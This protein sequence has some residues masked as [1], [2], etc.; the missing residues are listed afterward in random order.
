MISTSSSD[1]V[2]DFELDNLNAF[3]ESVVDDFEY[4]L[5]DPD[6]VRRTYSPTI[7]DDNT[8]DIRNDS[9]SESDDSD[10]S[11][12]E[13]VNDIQSLKMQNTIEALQL[14]CVNFHKA[15]SLTKFDPAKWAVFRLHFP[16]LRPHFKLSLHS[17]DPAEL[18]L[19]DTGCFLNVI[20]KDRRQELISRFGWEL[21]LEPTRITLRSHTGHVVPSLGIISLSVFIPDEKGETVTFPDVKFLVTRDGGHLLLGNGFLLGRQAHLQYAMPAEAGMD[22]VDAKIMFPRRAIS[23]PA[24]L[25]PLKPPPTEGYQFRLYPVSEHQ[26]LP[27][28]KDIPIQC[29]VV[30]TDPDHDT[31]IRNGLGIAELTAFTN[32]LNSEC[33]IS[34]NNDLK[35]VILLRNDSEYPTAVNKEMC[36]GMGEMVGFRDELCAD[37]T[38][39]SHLIHTVAQVEVLR[40]HKCLCQITAQTIVACFVD[41]FGLSQIPYHNAFESADSTIPSYVFVPPKGKKRGQNPHL[42]IRAGKVTDEVAKEIVA[43]CPFRSKIIFVPSKEGFSLL[44]TATI[45][46]IQ[47]Q[48]LQ[49][50]VELYVSY[51]E[52][53]RRHKFYYYQPKSHTIVH[54][55]FS[56]TKGE[57]LIAPFTKHHKMR[58]C[59]PQGGTGVTLF[60]SSQRNYNYFVCKIDSKFK[61]NQDKCR[62]RVKETLHLLRLHDPQTQMCVTTN[63]PDEF[64]PLQRALM[65]EMSAYPGEVGNLKKLFVTNNLMCTREMIEIK[66]EVKPIDILDAFEEK[67]DYEMGIASIVSLIDREFVLP[68]VYQKKELQKAI[69]MGEAHEDNESHQKLL[70][71]IEQ[72]PD[73]ILDPVQ[74]DT[75]S[76]QSFDTLFDREGALWDLN[77]EHGDDNKVKTWRDLEGVFDDLDSKDKKDFYSGLYDKYSSIINLSKTF[78]NISNCPKFDLNPKVTQLSQKP[79]PLS[80]FHKKIMFLLIDKMVACGMLKEV[81]S[82][83]F[84]SPVFLVRRTSAMRHMGEKEF[85]ELSEKDPEKHW[86]AVVSFVGLNDTVPI[87]QSFLPSIP[88]LIDKFQGSCFFSS[89]DISSFYRQLGLTDRA[90]EAMTIVVGTDPPT[91]YQPQ[92][93]LE[94][95]ASVVQFANW[96]TGQF[97]RKRS[98]GSCEYYLDD[99]FLYSNSIEGIRQAAEDVLADL[100][101]ANLFFSPLKC[102]WEVNEINCLGYTIRYCPEDG[103]VRW[104]PQSQK[105][106][107][108]QEAEYPKN[109]HELMR[110]LGSVAFCSNFVDNL[111]NLS[112]SLYSLLARYNKFGKFTE[113]EMTETEKLSFRLLMKKMSNME[114]LAVCGAGYPLRGLVDSGHRGYAGTLFIIK[115]GKP[116]ICA[117]Y[118]KRYPASFVRSRS[119]CEKESMA[120]MQFA[121][122]FQDRVF[123]A[124]SVTFYSDCRVFLCLLARGKGVTSG[125]IPLRW[126]H[127]LSVLPIRFQHRPRHLLALPDYLARV[128][129]KEKKHEHLTWYAAKKDL[130]RCQVNPNKLK[131]DKAYNINDLEDIVVNSGN[132]LI[133]EHPEDCDECKGLDDE[134]E[135]CSDFECQLAR[136]LEQ[137]ESDEED[138]LEEEAIEAKAS[139]LP[140]PIQNLPVVKELPGA[141][142]DINFPTFPQTGFDVDKMVK[143][144]RSDPEL[145]KIIQTL[146][147][148]RPVPRRMHQYHLLDGTMLCKKIDLKKEATKD[149]LQIMVPQSAFIK[150]VVDS[151]RMGHMSPSKLHDLLKRF[152]YC[153]H[154][155]NLIKLVSASCRTCVLAKVNT[156]GNL[157]QGML[158]P[159][160]RTYGTLSMDYWYPGTPTTRNG[161]QYTTVLTIVDYFSL[162]VWC[163]PMKNTQTD[164]FLKQ[165]DFFLGTIPA[166]AVDFV[167][168]DNAQGLGATQAVKDYFAKRNI[169]VRTCTPYN[170]QAQLA[171]RANQMIRN[172][173]RVTMHSYDKDW[174][175][176]LPLAQRL[177]NAIPHH[178][179][180]KKAQGRSP[181]EIAFGIVSPF[182]PLKH[183]VTDQTSS[184]A[185][186]RIRNVISQLQRA[187][188]RVSQEIIQ[189]R[190]ATSKIKKGVTVALLKNK[191]DRPYKQD[192]YYHQRP[193]RV[194]HKKGHELVIV[195][196]NN[197]TRKLRVNINRVKLWGRLPKSIFDQLSDDQKEDFV[198]AA[199]RKST[200]TPEPEPPL[201]DRAKTP[202]TTERA[203]VFQ[204]LA[205]KDDEKSSSD[206]SSETS[207]QQEQTAPSE[208]SSPVTTT[209]TKKSK[210]SSLFRSVISRIRKIAPSFSSLRSRSKTNSTVASST[211]IQPPDSASQV[212][213]NL[214]PPIVTAGNQSNNQQDASKDQSDKVSQRSSNSSH[215][216]TRDRP[217]RKTAGQKAKDP[218][219]Q[220]F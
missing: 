102:K 139:D 103:V 191:A 59:D 20:S 1:D 125:V 79:F 19:V 9:D 198:P 117:F 10:D 33:V 211:T 37:V 25:G 201:P 71:E 156:S 87:P 4:H 218:A 206:S 95:I 74:H 190:L 159:A 24:P 169:Q 111:A 127:V 212:P 18:V 168:T 186:R 175:E 34:I 164:Q 143:E 147:M 22:N 137:F 99:C 49:T 134:P 129:S 195:P 38:P 83:R 105:I 106:K 108:F 66:R 149:N 183:L 214:T 110:I 58:A 31:K 16:T 26:E 172:V 50:D 101:E 29:N 142:L 203:D 17:K 179:R 207:V 12:V 124:E 217:Q 97:I 109:V 93:V 185:R 13:M 177:L 94:G 21:P 41:P 47:E 36:V 82:S 202:E 155:K 14:S 220:Y 182:D 163:Y 84:A 176:A 208:T 40:T 128:I 178:D 194:V 136:E 112:A 171:E 146:L 138:D 197:P 90:K 152:F 200:V 27:R 166:E 213:T 133:I 28:H 184:R 48:T 30:P 11:G 78:L 80:P 35:T 192:T 174:Y 219:Y 44:E 120:N 104:L 45:D 135:S 42:F 170:S 89:I 3:D 144:Q 53:C 157:P 73:P 55:I 119:S 204:Q 52:A 140:H 51:F 161:I 85:R 114:A 132:E 121:L 60:R 162:F 67:L 56:D 131:V 46:K 8:F 54:F 199:S 189:Q 145:M 100:K 64:V 2:S 32:T 150:I 77:T 173:L 153:K 69:K 160:R 151:H 154:A 61:E 188:Y 75:K 115:D 88:Q 148:V 196:V 158:P 43:E 5:D 57:D 98:K 180:Y 6:T 76:E 215:H 72:E 141:R 15:E 187:R 116:H 81:H 86:R 113:F 96:V 210:T 39:I 181:V 92:V 91:Y 68:N 23:N 7:H 70:E 62:S 126:L 107:L 118:S 167:I 122:R 63:L 216:L 165:M 209:K 123:S 193:Y 130:K 205:S 65:A